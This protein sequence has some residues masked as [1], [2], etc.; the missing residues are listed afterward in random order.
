MDLMARSSVARVPPAIVSRPCSQK[1]GTIPEQAK[2]FYTLES[3]NSEMQGLFR[4][5]VSGFFIVP[6]LQ[7]AFERILTLENRPT[8]LMQR[9]HEL[10]QMLRER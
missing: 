9:I 4:G 6:T 2:H 5:D 8:E 3:F 1:R 7:S 10:E